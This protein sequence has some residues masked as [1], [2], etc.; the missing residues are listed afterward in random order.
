MT[1]AAPAGIPL[2][3]CQYLVPPQVDQW[4]FVAEHDTLLNPLRADWP[5]GYG[6]YR[7]DKRNGLLGAATK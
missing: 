5:G 2:D 7:F 6:I 3:P 1:V 4:A